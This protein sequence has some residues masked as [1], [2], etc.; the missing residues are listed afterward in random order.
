VRPAGNPRA[1]AS[2]VAAMVALAAV[3]AGVVLARYSE[4]VTLVSSGV[5][6]APLGIV[7]GMY[8]VV[9]SRRARETVLRTLGRSGG[10]GRAHVGRIIGIAGLCLSIT[11]GL[12]LAFYGL[13]VLFAE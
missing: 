6:S 1:T 11:A 7:L 13:L 10:T 12:A 4:Q 3:P 8:A 9:L 5:A 2:V